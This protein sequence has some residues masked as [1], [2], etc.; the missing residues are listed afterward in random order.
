MSKQKANTVAV[1][2]IHAVRALLNTAPERILELFVLDGADQKAEGISAVA[3]SLGIKS[4]AAKRGQLDE[5]AGG[6]THQGVLAVARPAPELGESDLKMLLAT[7]QVKTLLALDHIQD[8]HNLGACIRTAEAAGID[9]LIVSK[10]QSAPLGAVARKV[11]CGAAETLPIYRVANL[12][13]A[14]ELVKKEGYWLIGTSDGAEQDLYQ[15]KLS[16]PLCFVVGSEGDGVKPLIAKLCDEMVRIP[17]RGAVSSVNVS[18]AT[19]I[20]LF[21]W[22]RQS[23]K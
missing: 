9:A 22:L 3:Q 13:R 8:P 10:N 21:E 12:A 2:G 17:M 6:Y 5:W 14:L 11:A 7:S 23:Q 1:F 16:G 4:Q 20:I 18:V 15:T 19:G